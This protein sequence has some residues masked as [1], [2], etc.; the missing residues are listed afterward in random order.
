MKKQSLY[1]NIH[2]ILEIIGEFPTN[3]FINEATVATP[4]LPN[5]LKIWSSLKSK[6]A[7]ILGLLKEP[8]FDRTGNRTIAHTI[9][10]NGSPRT[11]ESDLYDLINSLIT[12]SGADLATAYRNFITRG[13]K[14]EIAERINLLVKAL[15][16]DFANELYE[17]LLTEL[18]TKVPRDPNLPVSPG[19]PLISAIKS[20]GEL[21]YDLSKA[22]EL[23]QGSGGEFNLKNQI[24]TWIQDPLQLEILYPKIEKRFKEYQENPKK[25][26]PEVGKPGVLTRKLNEKEQKSLNRLLGTTSTYWS[27]IFSTWSETL[28]ELNNE[29][30][31]YMKGLLQ[32]LKNAKPENVESI[33]NAYTIKITTSLNKLKI[34][35]REEAIEELEKM[36]LPEIVVTKLKDDPDSFYKTFRENFFHKAGQVNADVK[37]KVISA[38]GDAFKTFYEAAIQIFK[39]VMKFSFDFVRF[40]WKDAFEPLLDPRTNLGNFLLTDSWS[41]LNKMYGLLVKYGWNNQ[42]WFR[43][44]I[45]FFLEAT[46]WTNIAYVAGS[47]ALG[48]FNATVNLIL[49]PLWDT[50]MSLFCFPGIDLLGMCGKLNFNAYK[51]Y[52]TKELWSSIVAEI[53]VQVKNQLGLLF[54]TKDK[55]IAVEFAKTLPVIG[56]A[57]GTLSATIP[58][59]L[60]ELTGLNNF[61]SEKIKKSQDEFNNNLRNENFTPGVDTLFIDIP[62]PNMDTTG[63]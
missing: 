33:T 34:R 62:V 46:L 61:F 6:A 21:Y 14:E 49:K 37:G 44:N 56:Q 27:K 2:R 43:G 28:E 41:G 29:I 17:K 38:V 15:G 32:D 55:R 11:I 59:T 51:D 45:K 36:G 47:I 31:G 25:F 5:P 20:E 54:S 10:I 3:N 16:P 9:N 13:T 50:F 35:M 57:V 60:S 8:K 58:R 26:V 63:N 40:K 19:N 53:L 42:K 22:Q 1:E 48:V 12:T 24:A 30:D 18:Q 23:A 52:F 4:R 7:D 39:T